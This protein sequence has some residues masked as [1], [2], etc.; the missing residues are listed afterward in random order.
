MKLHKQKELNQR[1]KEKTMLHILK[2]MVFSDFQKVFIHHL[3]ISQRL[4]QM[5]AFG[6]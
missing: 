4:T 5:G 2:Q 6:I 3:R 1:N